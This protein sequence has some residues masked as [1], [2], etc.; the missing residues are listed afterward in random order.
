MFEK[1]AFYILHNYPNFGKAIFGKMALLD[2]SGFGKIS[3]YVHKA[4][5]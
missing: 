1:Q 2:V 5:V 4:Y 3:Y